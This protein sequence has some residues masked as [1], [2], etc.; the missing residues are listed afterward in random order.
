MFK[1]MRSTIAAACADA[2]DV[3]IQTQITRDVD[4]KHTN[5]AVVNSSVVS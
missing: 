5:M 2:R 3:V 4:I 1:L